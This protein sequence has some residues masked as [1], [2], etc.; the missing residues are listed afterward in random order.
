VAG[1]SLLESVPLIDHHCHGVTFAELGAV[2]FDELASESSA[3]GRPGRMLGASQLGAVIRAECAPI[4]GLPRHCSADEYQARRC[5]LDATEVNRRLLTATGISSY[6]IDTGYRGS[7]LLTPEQMAE[8][9]GQSARE[10]VR[11][12][13]VAEQLANGDVSADGFA[14]AYAGA[15]AE[16]AQGA[17]GLKS[18][19]AYRFGLD[20]DPE[21]PAPRDV[22][23]AAGD[24]LRRCA[25][26]KRAR[27][28]DP[29]LLRHL[30]WAGVD[31]GLPLQFHVGFGDSDI[32]LH[33]CDPARMTRFI[34]AVQPLGTQVMLLH[35][36]PYHRQAG[37]L[38]HVYP[39]V[40]FDTG[41]AVSHSGLGSVQLIRESLEVAPFDKVL[42]STD[43]F[44]LAELYLCGALLWR[45]GLAQ[46]MD[47]W[48]ARDWLSAADAERFAAMMANGNAR[49]AYDLGWHQ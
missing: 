30:L 9:S 37:Y 26:E 46:V 45:R 34:Q 16:A 47:E 19:M 29:V 44:G 15:L 8:V 42:F 12:E 10:V 23:R 24:W 21:R 3:L 36:Y 17:V 33:R 20:F 18:V 49:R 22:I 28:D 38:A 2:Q 25:Q 6:F 31:L 39:H 43:A 27:L 14:R 7:E 13:A 48:L 5:E 11:L 4:L 1:S 35:C 32:V 41:S 40:W